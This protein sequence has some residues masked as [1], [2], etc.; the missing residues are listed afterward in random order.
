MGGDTNVNFDVR[1]Y[2]TRHSQNGRKIWIVTTDSI[3]QGGK[4]VVL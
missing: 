4:L 2:C 3:A 1:R